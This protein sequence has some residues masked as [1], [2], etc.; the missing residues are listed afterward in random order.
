M[1]VSLIL[2]FWIIFN[3]SKFTSTIKKLLQQFYFTQNNNMDNI[4]D[5]KYEEKCMGMTE[6]CR[7]LMQCFQKQQ[8]W[9]ATELSS[10][11]GLVSPPKKKRMYD[12]VDAFI[13]IGLVEKETAGRDTRYTFV[14]KRKCTCTRLQ[15]EERSK[16]LRILHEKKLA[17]QAEIDQLG[18][19]EKQLLE[20]VV[21][22]EEK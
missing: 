19:E 4:D 14:E 9:M 17:L 20:D 13:G 7:K 6:L 10:E 5:K 8:V 11:L 1:L 21:K 12:G 3:I 18:E 22:L 2:V 15:D 16:K